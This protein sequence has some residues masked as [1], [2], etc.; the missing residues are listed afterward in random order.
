M[1]QPVK[2]VRQT[3]RSTLSAELTGYRAILCA[4]DPA[5]SAGEILI[6]VVLALFWNKSDTFH[7]MRIEGLWASKDTVDL[8]AG[9]VA[10]GS[11]FSLVDLCKN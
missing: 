3:K 4:T 5:A 7:P 8:E 9:P 1:K 6:F 11:T 2:S 10:G